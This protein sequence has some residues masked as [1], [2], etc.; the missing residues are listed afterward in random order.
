[1]TWRWKKYANAFAYSRKSCIPLQKHLGHLREY[2]KASPCPFRGSLLIKLLKKI[3]NY[4][5][6]LSKTK[7][8][9]ILFTK[10][11][12]KCHSPLSF[13]PQNAIKDNT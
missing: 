12:P 9:D 10:K 3:Q 8:L 7:K 2:A 11:K 6:S 13:P 1:M 4:K 5:I